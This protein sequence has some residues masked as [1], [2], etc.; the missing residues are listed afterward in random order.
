MGSPRPPNTFTGNEIWYTISQCSI[1][2][3]LLAL[4]LGKKALSL[5][6]TIMNLAIFL[7][8]CRT[9]LRSDTQTIPAKDG[10]HSVITLRVQDVTGKSENDTA[11]P[12]IAFQSSEEERQTKQERDL[13]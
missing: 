3:S 12:L 13:L 2:L 10:I 11:L 4:R 7:L 6:R 8:T 9:S 5:P 1:S